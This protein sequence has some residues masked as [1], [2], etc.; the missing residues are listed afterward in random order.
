MTFAAETV[1][2]SC[3]EVNGAQK[4]KCGETDE[5]CADVTGEHKTHTHTYKRVHPAYSCTHTK[6][7]WPFN[8]AQSDCININSHAGGDGGKFRAENL[9][10]L[11]HCFNQ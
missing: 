7:S 2:E 8:H 11:R 5:L 1:K 10:F 3:G 9:S 4:N 6:E